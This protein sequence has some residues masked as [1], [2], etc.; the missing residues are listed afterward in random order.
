MLGYLYNGVG[1]NP[2]GD[3]N[4][5]CVK[6]LVFQYSDGIVDVFFL[7]IVDYGKDFD[8]FYAF[9]FKAFSSLRTLIYDNV[10]GGVDF[11]KAYKCKLCHNLCS[12]QN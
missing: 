12:F 11:A 7:V 10:N 5:K 9:L 8:Q 2:A 6:G 3:A 4:H 1:G